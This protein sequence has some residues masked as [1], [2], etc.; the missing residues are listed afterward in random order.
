MAKYRFVD[1][2]QKRAVMVTVEPHRRVKDI[3][4]Y[5]L[6]PMKLP[7]LDPRMVPVIYQL[8]FNGR[9]LNGY[10]T[11]AAAGIPDGGTIDVQGLPTD[12][13]ARHPREWRDYEQLMALQEINSEVFEVEVM[14]RAF[15][16]AP[17]GYRLHIQGVAGPVADLSKLSPRGAPP[18]LRA[19]GEP[20]LRESFVSTILVYERYPFAKPEFFYEPP[21]LCHPNVNPSSRVACLFWRWRAVHSVPEAVERFITQISYLGFDPAIFDRE[22]SEEDEREAPGMRGPGWIHV[23]ND[24]ALAWARKYQHEHPEAL[25]FRNARG[26]GPP[27]LRRPE[28]FVGVGVHADRDDALNGDESDEIEIEIEVEEDE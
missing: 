14:G 7:R 8:A 28:G 27:A 15:D 25:P 1:Q 24:E 23:L 17:L 12:L 3:I 6:D 16:G 5:L 10:E 9:M 4:P 20:V 13:G 2:L 22:G 21:I 11:F 18:L 19:N 26:D